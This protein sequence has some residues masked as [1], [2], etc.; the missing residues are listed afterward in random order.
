MF[1]AAGMAQ[2]RLMTV[3]RREAI[4]SPDDVQA[5]DQVRRGS[6]VAG[7]LP[8]LRSFNRLA[9]LHLIWL[10]NR[11][12][13]ERELN[14]LHDSLTRMIVATNAYLKLPVGAAQNGRRFL[15][16]IEPLLDPQQTDAR[17]YGTDYVVVA[18][19]VDGVIRMS[20]ATFSR[21][22]PSTL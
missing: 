20:R 11:P 3:A 9:N 19:P 17:V 6:Q 8:L 5:A 16:V 22:S 15:V 10:H 18:S 14:Q 7:I 4:A 13:Y 21:N 1:T 2:A 12:G